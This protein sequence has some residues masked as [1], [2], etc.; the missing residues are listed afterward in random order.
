MKKIIQFKKLWLM[1]I[2]FSS[3]FAKAQIPPSDP[4]YTLFLQDDFNGTTLDSTKWEKMN[5]TTYGGGNA[6][7]RPQNVAVNN[8]T[9]ELTV[10]S[11]TYTI[12]STTLTYNYTS[13]FVRL[14]AYEPNSNNKLFKYGYIEVRANMPYLKDS[15]LWP[16][17]WTKSGEGMLD[18]WSE[19]EFELTEQFECTYCQCSCPVGDCQYQD[20]M[21]LGTGIFYEYGNCSNVDYVQSPI[22]TKF[23]NSWHTYA[24]DWSP[25][26]LVWYYD[27]ALIRILKNRPC[28]GKKENPSYNGGG[29]HDS[30]SLL[31]RMGYNGSGVGLPQKMYVDYVK[32]Y[33]L[34]QD[35]STDVISS[36]YNFTGYDNK[37]KDIIDIG[38]SGGSTT[39][40]SNPVISLKAKQYVL[41]DE[42]FST[43]ANSDIFIDVPGCGC[44]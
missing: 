3:F 15:Y 25:D 26:R 42:G 24:V 20:S 30:V 22:P 2:F 6:C 16:S 38:G 37:V 12:P 35:C 41:L 39:W 19:G 7:F 13:G 34:K 36:S 21:Q 29:I 10:K 1:I 31:L 27:G 5:N 9:L 43:P 28:A 40:P 11:E 14:N 32:I 8:G 18:H 23:G 44:N 17:L 4:S 33:Q